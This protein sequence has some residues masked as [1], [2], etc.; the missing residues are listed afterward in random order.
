MN[1][2]ARERRENVCL[3]RLWLIEAKDHID[4]ALSDTDELSDMNVK[5]IED[6]AESLDFAASALDAGRRHCGGKD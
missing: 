5:R 3:T 1:R 4:L 6:A 2:D